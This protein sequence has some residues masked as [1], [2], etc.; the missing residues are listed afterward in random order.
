[1][2][3]KTWGDIDVTI[4]TKEWLLLL[5][6]FGGTGNLFAALI[7]MALLIV[8]AKADAQKENEDNGQKSKTDTP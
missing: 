6:V 7:A 4:T 8:S 2:A 5:L 3:I 1:M